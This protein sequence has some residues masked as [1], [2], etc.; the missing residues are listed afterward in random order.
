V[1]MPAGRGDFWIAIG[2][3]LHEVSPRDYP[4]LLWDISRRRR[5]LGSSAILRPRHDP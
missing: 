3:D 2:Q 5:W 4:R 1:V